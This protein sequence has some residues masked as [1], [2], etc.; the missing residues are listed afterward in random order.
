MYLYNELVFST[1]VFNDGSVSVTWPSDCLTKLSWQFKLSLIRDR[2][3]LD[4][5]MDNDRA[6]N[7]AKP[8]DTILL[9][10]RN[11]K[12]NQISLLELVMLGICHVCLS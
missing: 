2:V 11:P 12:L 7:M 10:W 1:D 8:K 3:H 4:T 5:M 9:A 6:K